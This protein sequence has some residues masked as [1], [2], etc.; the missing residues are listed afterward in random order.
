VGAGIALALTGCLQATGWTPAWRLLP[1][2]VPL[3]HRGSIAALRTGGSVDRFELA[4]HCG[5]VR[6]FCAN[7]GAARYLTGYDQVILCAYRNLRLG[8]ESACGDLQ[9]KGVPRIRAAR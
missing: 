2:G 8:A 1:H 7:A 4:R 5:D 3:L 6:N 9:E